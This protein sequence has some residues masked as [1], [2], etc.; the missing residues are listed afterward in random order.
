MKEE[1]LKLAKETLIPIGWYGEKAKEIQG[2]EEFIE[3]LSLLLEQKEDNQT[4][5]K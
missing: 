5:T 3:K 4:H 1:I 2:L